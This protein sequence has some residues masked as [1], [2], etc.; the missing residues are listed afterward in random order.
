M[1]IS[2]LSVL[3]ITVGTFLTLQ[4]CCTKMDCDSVSFD[5]IVI[6]FNSIDAQDFQEVKITKLNK[7]NGS[8]ISEFNT[9][10]GNTMTF[11][12]L[13]NK[14][15]E[16][17]Y[18]LENEPFNFNYILQLRGGVPD[19]IYDISYNK[20]ISMESCNKCL[21]LDGRASAEIYSNLMFKYKGG[22][23]KSGDT[24]ELNQ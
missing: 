3:I 8:V 21:L 14:R 23:Y 15:A 13:P 10:T 12:K 7:S 19:T 22:T 18:E 17:L 4:S 11:P 20:N 16:E 1:N 2:K 5:P 9:S 6:K 24:L